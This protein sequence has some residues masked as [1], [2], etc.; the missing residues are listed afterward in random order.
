MEKLRS[1]QGW[2]GQFHEWRESIRER[3][4]NWRQ[5][6]PG[7]VIESLKKQVLSKSTTDDSTDYSHIYRKVHANLFTP[8]D[9]TLSFRNIWISFYL[10]M[11]VLRRIFLFGEINGQFSGI[12]NVGVLLKL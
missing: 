8:I 6:N 10:I 3:F 4:S 11:Y 7:T 1:Y 2:I 5:E 9:L 12:V